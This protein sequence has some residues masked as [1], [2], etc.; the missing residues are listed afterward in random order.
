MA[1]CVISIR[2]RR[3]VEFT[4]FMISIGFVV[5]FILGLIDDIIKLVHQVF[6]LIIRF[7]GKAK[8]KDALNTL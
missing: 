8:R 4:L 7:L 2:F 3:S 1:R 6:M 5:F